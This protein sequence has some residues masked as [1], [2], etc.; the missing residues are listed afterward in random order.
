MFGIIH[1]RTVL[2]KAR[3]ICFESFDYDNVM[4]EPLV[5]P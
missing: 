3:K 2:R 4:S 5:A 1:I